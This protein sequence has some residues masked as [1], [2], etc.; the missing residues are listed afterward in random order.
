[1]F[2]NESNNNNYKHIFLIDPLLLGI[3]FIED[4][5]LFN[6]YFDIMNYAFDKISKNINSKLNETLNTFPV[7]LLSNYD[8]DKDFGY[9]N[10]LLKPFYNEVTD[11]LEFLNNIT[12]KNIK[13]D[14]N[15]INLCM[16]L[17]EP[18]I[19]CKTYKSLD[20]YKFG[21]VI[22]LEVDKLKMFKPT[23]EAVHHFLQKY[24]QCNIHIIPLAIWDP[25]IPIFKYILYR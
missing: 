16:N 12:L 10:D 11:D 23:F 5:D 13:E 14:P 4:E 2:D 19:I 6:E 22:D 25:S 17:D 8:N 15:Q 7:E 20:I 1:M 18:I 21:K 3:D 9:F 24:D